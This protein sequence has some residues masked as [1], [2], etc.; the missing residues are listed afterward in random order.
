MFGRTQAWDRDSK[1]DCE[2]LL[3]LPRRFAVSMAWNLGLG[4]T[5]R[6]RPGAAKHRLCWAM[7]P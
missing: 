7:S 5:M 2:L 6:G 1:E 4:A 3:L